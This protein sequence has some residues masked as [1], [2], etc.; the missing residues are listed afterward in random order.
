MMGSEAL[1]GLSALALV[2]QVIASYPTSLSDH[3]L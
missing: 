3:V 1:A 2:P